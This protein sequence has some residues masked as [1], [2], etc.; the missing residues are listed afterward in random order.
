MSK[1]QDKIKHR[2]EICGECEHFIDFPIVH[3]YLKNTH[4]CDQCGCLME[5]KVRIPGMKC[6]LD[7][8]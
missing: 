5:V 7:K 4:Q 3:K 1:F 6:P 2:L 8:W